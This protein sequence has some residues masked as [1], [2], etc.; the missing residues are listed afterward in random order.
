MTS[1]PGAV[2]NDSNHRWAVGTCLAA[3]HCPGIRARVVRRM[4]LKTA[5]LVRA[6]PAGRVDLGVHSVRRIP[7]PRHD[8]QPR[9]G[10]ATDGVF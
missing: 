5:A 3:A 2:A 9:P 6:K 1:L 7:A 8:A 4:Q 10:G